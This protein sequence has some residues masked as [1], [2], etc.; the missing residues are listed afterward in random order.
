MTFEELMAIENEAERVNATY[1]LFQENFRL[2]T[3]KASQVE[4]LTTY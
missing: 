4:F 2:N 3:T 1:S